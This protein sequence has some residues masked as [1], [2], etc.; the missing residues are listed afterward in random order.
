MYTHIHTL[1]H[2][3]YIHTYLQ[4]HVHTYINT[5]NNSSNPVNSKLHVTTLAVCSDS[6]VSLP[7]HTAD[8]KE[9]SHYVIIKLR[10]V[11]IQGV[12]KF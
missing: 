10:D 5:H 4:T 6:S 11:I 1:I 7:I 3:T 12:T 8:C 9:T 2:N